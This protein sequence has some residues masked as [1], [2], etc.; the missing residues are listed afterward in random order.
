MPGDPIMSDMPP[1]D[2]ITVEV[3]RSY[4]KSTANQMSTTLVRGSFSPVLYE[5][6]DFSLGLYNHAAELIAEG[7]GFPVFMGTLTFTI[8]AVMDYVGR[9][10][11][12]DG[13]VILC[14][15]PYWTGAHSQDAVTIRPI[16]IDGAIFGYAAAKA[17]WMDLGAKDI[18][19]TDTTD[20]WQ[21]GLQL[22]GVRI[23]KSGALDPELVEI[24]RVNSRLPDILIG[25]LTA[26]LAACDLGV[27]RVCA[28]VE[29]H[30][31]HVVARATAAMLDHSERLARQAIAAMPDGAW[32]AE[33]SLDNDGISQEPVPIRLRL[34]IDGD[35][36]VVDL[37]GSAPQ[38]HGPVNCPLASTISALRLTMKM[39]I[40]PHHDANEGFF[41]P[42]EVR[43]PEG[44]VVNPSAPS[45]VM[46]YGWCTNAIGEALFAAFCH[47]A[48]AK[49]VAHSGGDI[50]ALLFSGHDPKTGAYFAGVGD[51]G[52]GAGAAADQDGESVLIHFCLGEGRNIPVEILEERFPILSESYALL[53]DSAGPGRYR[54]GLGCERQWRFLSKVS[55]ISTLERTGPAPIGVDG[56]FAAKGNVLILRPGTDREARVGK[57]SGHP[58]EG[59]ERICI[60]TR[61]GAGWG[62][63]LDRP[64]EN[65]LADVL[66]G[67]VSMEA[68]RRDYGVFIRNDDGDFHIDEARTAQARAARREGVPPTPSKPKTDDNPQDQDHPPV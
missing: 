61:G 63:P 42:L 1:V 14:T 44:T 40:A 19:A 47:A 65:V 43:A 60:Q 30:G 6:R 58:I 3:I 35:R 59:G 54:G 39:V 57:L 56:G 45:P 24:L 32:S 41:R 37:A 22:K 62:T 23:V 64:L 66:A 18:F 8:R 29:K 53:A 48:P 4:Y 17:H 38:T 13:D 31:S 36:I 33:V 16:F 20:I 15:Y 26:Q 9:D 46:C 28:L 7:R 11:V 2:P 21:E 55:L 25:D 12:K 5:V 52:C 50:A 27:R 68:A 10:S 67:Y 51:E 34:V 49:S